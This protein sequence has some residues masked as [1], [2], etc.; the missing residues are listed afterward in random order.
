VQPENVHHSVHKNIISRHISQPTLI[1]FSHRFTS[2]RNPQHCCLGHF[3]TSVSSSV[4]FKCPSEYFSIQLWTLLR[5]KHFPTLIRKHFLWISFALSPFAN[6]KLHNRTLIFGSTPSKH[7]RHL[8]YW[9][10][11]LNMRMRVCYLDCHEAGPCCYLMIQ[12]TNYI[13][14]SCFTSIC[15][16]FSDSPSYFSHNN[17][18]FAT[19]NV[20]GHPILSGCLV[21]IL[22]VKFNLY[23]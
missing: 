21:I 3:R 18:H 15:D 22:H 11:P 14:H 12:K 1:H 8:D 16:L 19:T 5:E 10:Q 13:H 17:F 20:R 7:G 23:P 9:N 6:K 4:T 2:R